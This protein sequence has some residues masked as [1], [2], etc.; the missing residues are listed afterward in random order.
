MAR[1][2]AVVVH[3]HDGN[4]FA[5]RPR[6]EHLVRPEHVVVSQRRP[7]FWLESD[8]FRLEFSGVLKKERGYSIARHGPRTRLSVVASHSKSCV[9]SKRAAFQVRGLG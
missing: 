4:D 6:D 1:A 3:E 8:R 9:A 5:R 2:D 7:T